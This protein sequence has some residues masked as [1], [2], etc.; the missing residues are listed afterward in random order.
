MGR[1]SVLA[2]EE[3]MWGGVGKCVWVWG[4]NTLPH[5]SFL[6]SPFPTSPLTFP[7]PQHTFLHLPLIPLPTSRPT[8]QHIFLL[9]PPLPSPS[10]SVAKL[11]CYEVSVAKLLWQSYHVAKLL[12]TALDTA[13]FVIFMEK[14]DIKFNFYLNSLLPLFGTIYH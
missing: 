13:K 4:P 3:R 11:P 14:H 7:T 12:A 6:T 1:G 8:P 9:S 2:C 10:Q 5:I